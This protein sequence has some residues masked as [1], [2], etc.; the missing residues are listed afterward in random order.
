MLLRSQRLSAEQ[1]ALVMKNGRA[2]HSALFLLRV[3]GVSSTTRIST[4]V[5]VKVAKT[6]VQRNKFRRKMYEATQLLIA[7][8]VAHTHIAIIAKPALLQ[9]TQKAI[10]TEMKEV[11]VK[12][13]LLR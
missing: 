12:G 3:S 13:K 9:S 1:F 10:E 7:H 8:V 11:F 5:P 4:T 2:L 6:A